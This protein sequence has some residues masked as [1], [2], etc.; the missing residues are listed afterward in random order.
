MSRYSLK[1][2]WARTFLPYCFHPMKVMGA[3]S[4]FIYLPLNRRYKPLGWI[5][6]EHV[7]YEQF[8][9]NFIYFD[10]D[11]S[12]LDVWASWSTPAPGDK[13]WL[14]DDSERSRDGY[15]ERLQRLERHMRDPSPHDLEA[16]KLAALGVDTLVP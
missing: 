11:P 7:V 8:W 3:R 16:A 5:G 4:H 14:Y 2:D 10:C 15:G 9:R 13:L 12:K 1:S 6:V